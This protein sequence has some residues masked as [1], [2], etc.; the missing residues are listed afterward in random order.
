MTTPR[1]SRTVQASRLI[2]A[3]V[4]R[5][6]AALADREALETW[7]PPRDM[8]GRFEWFDPTPGG[9]NRLVLTYTDP[10][11]FPGK[12][13]A[14]SDVVDG[15][16][17]DIVVDD[18]V[19]QAVDFDAEDPAFSGTMTMTM[20][21]SVHEEAGSTRVEIIARDV[22]D[23]ISADDHAAGLASTLQNLAGFVES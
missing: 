4:R 19:V 12:S 2:N 14:N 16:F 23:G 6:F 1:R 17:L 15:R 10:S 8:V 7:L 22:P 18:R 11:A 13:T 5:V 20:T 3:P 21:W 9:S